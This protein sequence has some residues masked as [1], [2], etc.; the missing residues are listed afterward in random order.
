[1]LIHDNVGVGSSKW[2]FGSLYV[3]L[4]FI[5]EKLV[6]GLICMWLCYSLLKSWCT[7]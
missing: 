3:A 1:M 5:V 4:L 2:W 7:V 6:H